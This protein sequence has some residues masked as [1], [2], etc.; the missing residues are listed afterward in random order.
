MDLI[1]YFEPDTNNKFINP[2]TLK[3]FKFGDVVNGRIFNRISNGVPQFF[4][5]KETYEKANERRESSKGDRRNANMVAHRI[6]WNCRQR[7]KLK[8]G[9]TDIS[10]NRLENEII[11]GDTKYNIKFCIST[12][13]DK[14][15]RSPFVPSLDRIDNNNP[16]YIFNDD[17]SMDTCCLV[18]YGINNLRNIFEDK[19]MVTI[20]SAYVRVHSREL[21]LVKDV[22]VQTD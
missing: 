10:V 4:M 8:G 7:S 15:K 9:I 12:E 3:V 16:N 5:S 2:N 18:P 14:S 11:K 21:S 17:P 13:N 6:L 22:Q 1:N 20:A 19:D